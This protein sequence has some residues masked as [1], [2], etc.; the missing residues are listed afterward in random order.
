MTQNSRLI[1]SKLINYL[2]FAFIMSVR[3]R[4]VAGFWGGIFLTFPEKEVTAV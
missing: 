1:E 2:G 4:S 3:D